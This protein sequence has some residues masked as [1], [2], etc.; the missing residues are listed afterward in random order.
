[1]EKMTLSTLHT[2]LLDLNTG[3]S[4]QLPSLPQPKFGITGGI[5]GDIPLVI[6]GRG[7]YGDDEVLQVGKDAIAS[8]PLPAV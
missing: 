3:Q 1:M 2:E 5:L 7:G 6:G 4:I 8:S